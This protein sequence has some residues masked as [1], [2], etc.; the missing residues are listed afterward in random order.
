[1][2]STFWLENPRILVDKAQIKELWPAHNYDM[3]RKLNAITRFIIILTILGFLYKREIK[4]LFS[5]IVTLG[6]IVI[7][8]KS[9]QKKTKKEGFESDVQKNYYEVNKNEFKN[10]SEQNPFMNNLIT[11]CNNEKDALP[12]YE[13]E[14]EDSIYDKVKKNQ[15]FN[16]DPRLYC[17]LGDNMQF[18]QSMRQFYT[19]ANTKTPNDQ[20][21]FAE[22]LYGNMPSCKDGDSI[23]CLKKAPGAL[24][25]PP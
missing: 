8:Y 16:S 10:P 22:W 15:N 9:T 20:K 14:I 18:E 5:T 11:D 1:M 4:V 23:Q 13:K 3:A 17:D 2:S 19:T 6:I 21:A 12:S 25:P 24:N 7:V